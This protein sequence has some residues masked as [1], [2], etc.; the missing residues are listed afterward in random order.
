MYIYVYIYIFRPRRTQERLFLGFSMLNMLLSLWTTTVVPQRLSLLS[1][2][3]PFFSFFFLFF[4]FFLFSYPY[5]YTQ[6][7]HYISF[8]SFIYIYCLYFFLFKFQIFLFFF[9]FC[10]AWNNF[11][12][13]KIIIFFFFC[14]CCWFLGLL[15]LELFLLFLQVGT[16]ARELCFLRNLIVDW[17]LWQVLTST[18]VFLFAEL[19][20]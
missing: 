11:F 13:N 19:T 20:K 6:H 10:E 16:R 15:H 2:S 7:T 17:C 5:I 12:I 14:C 3:N 1:E 8:V 9:I 4:F 18:P